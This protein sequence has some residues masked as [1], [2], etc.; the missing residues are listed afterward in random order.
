MTFRDWTK[1]LRPASYR[2]VPFFVEG[3]TIDTGR[4]LEVHEFPHSD[5]P[6]VEDLGRVANHISVTAYVLS[7][8]ADSEEKALR[9]ACERGGAALLSLPMERLQAH[10]ENCSR[11]FSK[12]RLGF[13]GFQLDFVREGLAGG[14]PFP[15]GFLSAIVARSVEALTVPL[16]MA[17]AQAYNA[18]GVPGFVI[19]QAAGEIRSVAA[20]GDTFARTAPVAVDR[21]PALLKGAA[22][23]YDQAPTL[24]QSGAVGQRL[25]NASYV[26]TGDA[27]STAPIVD[28]LLRLILDLAT[29]LPRDEALRMLEPFLTFNASV[30]PVGVSSWASRVAANASAIGSVVRIAALA[31][32]CRR[33]VETEYADRR[34]AIQMRAD[35]AEMTNIELDRLVGWRDFDI[36][37]EI[38]A[39]SGRTA[40]FLSR[41]I[42]DL[43]PVNIVEA[44]RTMPS[45][46][47]ANR[48]YGDAARSGELVA[49]NSV[50]HPSF[51]PTSFEALAR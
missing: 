51:M 24:A 14:G 20:L 50:I 17:F 46:W 8:R 2:G 5:Q 6:Y 44:P 40:E 30:P 34:E 9:A 21:V 42:A 3:D 37:R 11:D 10:C 16:R 1:T 45:L 39:L 36:Y 38:M 47:W 18:L 49:R 19:D 7:D 26:A 4:R 33:A 32:L 41:K 23:L 31:A 15:V 35:V 22:N 27:V 28:A 13:V 12:D 25:G 48:L 43:A 29:D